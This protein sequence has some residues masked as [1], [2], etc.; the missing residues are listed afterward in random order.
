MAE[1]K[2]IGGRPIRFAAL[3]DLRFGGNRGEKK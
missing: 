2:V 1:A 3:F